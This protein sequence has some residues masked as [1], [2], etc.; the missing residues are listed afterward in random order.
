[1]ITLPQ[2]RRRDTFSGS[3]LAVASEKRGCFKVRKHSSLPPSF[4]L[5]LPPPRFTA[6]PTEDQEQD[7]FACTPCSTTIFSLF[8]PLCKCLLRGS[9][10]TN[11]PV[12]FPILGTLS[13]RRR[14]RQ[15]ER[16]RTKGLM[17]RTMALHVHDKTLYISQ[18]SS[19]K[20]QR[21]IT[22]FCVCKTT[23]VP[24]SN[25]SCFYWKMK[26]AFTYST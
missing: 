17:S 7:S 10:Y 26:P 22:T 2:I 23:R 16:G 11:C 9:N 25:F 1:M 6:S 4:F 3:R 12:S 13:K 15:W 24:T 21:Q 20:E 8:K 18:P 19:A 14:Q 5:A